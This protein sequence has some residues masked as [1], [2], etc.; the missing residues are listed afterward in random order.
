MQS[1]SDVSTFFFCI[2][3]DVILQLSVITKIKMYNIS[4]CVFCLYL[5]SV[6][7]NFKVKKM[8]V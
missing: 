3:E 6:K 1:K 4:S 7:E 8:C 5:K 2:L